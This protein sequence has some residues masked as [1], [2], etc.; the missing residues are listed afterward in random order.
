[1][2]RTM[3]LT[4]ELAARVAERAGA[5]EAGPPP[6]GSRPATDD[7]HLTAIDAL[8]SNKPTDGDIW[9]FAYGSLIWSPKCDFAE[10][11][12]SLA[13]G[14]RRRFCLGWDLWFR[15][16]RDRPGLMLALDRGGECRGV[17]YRLPAGE[18]QANL[19][20]L[21]RH[22]ARII[23]TPFPARWIRITT[24]DGP[25][26]AVTFAIDRATRGYV[27][28]LSPGEVADVL[29]TATGQWGSMAEY[30]Q[31]TVA[32]LE[33]LGLHDRSLWSL[34][35]MVAERIETAATNGG[36]LRRADTA[37]PA[38]GEDHPTTHARPV[39]GRRRGPIAGA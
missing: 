4:P 11:Q 39:R 31:N 27:G 35:E 17:A 22:E 5:V 14:W 33:D 2:Q 16:S 12:I 32:H 19:L 37:R 24:D 15:G 23:P 36:P 18:E 13:R 1:M 38:Q 20:A 26:H 9:V 30:L 29:A 10:K 7:D 28:H 8:L 25:L 3:R 21:M 6:Q 34:Q